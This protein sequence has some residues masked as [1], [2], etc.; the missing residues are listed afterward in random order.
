MVA[1]DED[2]VVAED[3]TEADETEGD[4]DDDGSLAWLNREAGGTDNLRM[5]VR[6][7]WAS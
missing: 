1:A 2:V 6:P 7:L 4:C 5:Y 3:E